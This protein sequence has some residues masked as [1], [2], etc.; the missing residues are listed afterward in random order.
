MLQIKL[1][2][3]LMKGN[4]EHIPTFKAI[5]PDLFLFQTKRCVTFEVLCV[6]LRRGVNGGWP[7]AFVGGQWNSSIRSRRR[8]GAEQ[9]GDGGVWLCGLRPGSLHFPD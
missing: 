5:F 2:H 4:M 7:G 6:I 3:L 9:G 8:G 1:S